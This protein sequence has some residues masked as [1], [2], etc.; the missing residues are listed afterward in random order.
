MAPDKVPSVTAPGEMHVQSMGISKSLTYHT[1]KWQR[2]GSQPLEAGGQTHLHA[3]F[4]WV[5]TVL[6]ESFPG[7]ASPRAT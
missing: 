6:G 5:Q 4:T 3:M 1:G 7:R 2:P